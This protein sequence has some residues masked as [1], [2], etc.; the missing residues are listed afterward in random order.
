LKEPRP[1]SGILRLFDWRH[2]FSTPNHPFFSENRQEYVA[3]GQLNIGEQ[4]KLGATSRIKTQKITF[5]ISI[6]I[7]FLTSNSTNSPCVQSTKSPFFAF[8]SANKWP[9]K[10]FRFLKM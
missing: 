9:L 10:Q 8:A 5:Q 3:V 2:Y 1:K 4:V 6:I 7:P